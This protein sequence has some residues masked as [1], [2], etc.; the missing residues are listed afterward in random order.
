MKRGS[1]PSHQF[2]QS[3]TIQN[4]YLG[5][6]QR[7]EKE[8]FIAV[9]L[10]VAP[11]DYQAVLAVKSRLKGNESTMNDLESAMTE[12]YCQRNQG[13]EMLL[14]TFTGIYYQ[15]GESGHRANDCPQQNKNNEG[16]W[17]TVSKAS[18]ILA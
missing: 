13:T 10:D 5:P 17:K 3:N 18:V 4:Q 16:P 1:N 14:G 11:E 15:C 2:G 6:R 12:Q 9:V 8:E 7:I